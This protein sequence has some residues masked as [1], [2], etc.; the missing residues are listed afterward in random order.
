MQKWNFFSTNE[1]KPLGWMK[2]QLKIQADGLNGNLDKVWRDVHDSAWI[3]G[4]AEGWELSL[5]HI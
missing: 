2:Q 3:G 4:D 1:I 5:I